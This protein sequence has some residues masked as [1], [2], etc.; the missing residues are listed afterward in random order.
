MLVSVILAIEQ[1]GT[2]YTQILAIFEGTAEVV[3][4]LSSNSK[5]DF[6]TWIGTVCRRCSKHDVTPVGH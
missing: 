6:V 4:A 1:M 2:T 3:F 5:L